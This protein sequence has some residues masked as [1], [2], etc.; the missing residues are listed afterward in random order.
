MRITSSRNTRRALL[1]TALMLLVAGACGDASAE[2]IYMWKDA[3][4]VTTFSQLPPAQGEHAGA[5]VGMQAGSAPGDVVAPGPFSW[6]AAP[7]QPVPEQQL[8]LTQ[9]ADTPAQQEA[10]E[11]LDGERDA[12]VPATPSSTRSGR[13]WH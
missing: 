3:R 12:G 9:P 1:P 11:A 7:V 10:R 2:G 4:N 13:A 5:L 8:P 6:R